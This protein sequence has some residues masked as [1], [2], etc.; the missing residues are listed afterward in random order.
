MIEFGKI[1]ALLCML[2]SSVYCLYDLVEGIMTPPPNVVCRE[3]GP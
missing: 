1:I 2:G 3:V